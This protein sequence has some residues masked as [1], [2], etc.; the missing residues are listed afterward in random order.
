MLRHTTLNK[1]FAMRPPKDEWDK[2][3]SG[4]RKTSTDNEP[5]TYINILEVLGLVD[6]CGFLSV[7]EDKRA[8]VHFAC[9]CAGQVLPIYEKDFPD[10]KRMREALELARSG[11]DTSDAVLNA[12]CAT[13][14]A[15][16]NGKRRATDAAKAS[17]YACD[18]SAYWAGQPSK[19]TG[20]FATLRS[21]AHFAT[22][23][24]GISDYP[25]ERYNYYFGEQDDAFDA[26]R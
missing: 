12:T 2:L 1:I 13:V 3:I 24:D 4:L 21:V 19:L 25:I 23:A 22:E 26:C 5:L 11:L 6:A 8:L 20:I 17:I 16:S 15:I 10:D 18:V 7:F 9:D 14:N